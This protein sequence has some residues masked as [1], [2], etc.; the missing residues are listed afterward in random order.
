M[1]E[2]VFASCR[3]CS[4]AGNDSWTLM[5]GCALCVR[6]YSRCDVELV[7]SAN[8]GHLSISDNPSRCIVI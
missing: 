3:G 8:D 4:N 1:P 5:S 2:R 6:C 7:G